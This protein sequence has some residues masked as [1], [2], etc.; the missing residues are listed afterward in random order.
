MIK[1]E[2]KTESVT[3]STIGQ[4]A[5]SEYEKGVKTVTSILEDKEFKG[6]LWTSGI[7][8][9]QLCIY[10][11]A[12]QDIEILY[13]AGT[14]MFLPV[15]IGWLRKQYGMQKSQMEVR[16]NILLDQNNALQLSNQL[17]EAELNLVKD[18]I[19]GGQLFSEMQ[20]MVIQT[21]KEVLLSFK[22]LFTVEMHKIM[23]DYNIQDKQHHR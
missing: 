18:G 10:A 12:K 14:S 7:L 11:Y 15:I 6:I 20:E 22:E 21:T 4:R 5:R 19:A 17:K 16:F 3:T 2:G 13:Y 23:A 8:L 1:N 9:I